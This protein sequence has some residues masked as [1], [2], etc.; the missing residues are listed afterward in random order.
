MSCFLNKCT[1]VCDLAIVC[2]IPNRLLL[3][4]QK[5]VKSRGISFVTC[6]NTYIEGQIVAVKECERIESSLRKRAS[7][8]SG[9]IKGKSGSIRH[10]K[11][12]KVHNLAIDRSELMS[13][14]PML[15]ELETLREEVD[16]FKEEMEQASEIVD[17]LREEM[18]SQYA[19]YLDEIDKK[20]AEID[21]L[22][23]GAYEKFNC[24][25]PIDQVGP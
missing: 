14:P 15:F 8:L 5:N 9:E 23:E 12:E 16:F 18:A 10:N 25:K 19:T 24:G 7:T 4:W 3:E 6:L 1:E 22:K 21:V 17:V 2:E 20:Q 11:L 13:V